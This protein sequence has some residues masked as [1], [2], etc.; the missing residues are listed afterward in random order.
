MFLVSV[1]GIV[2]LGVLRTS[3][4]GESVERALED[5]SAVMLGK[6]AVVGVLAGRL[7]MASA[8]VIRS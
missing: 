2:E 7:V 5:L 3:G 4:T 6:V 8:V 1:E